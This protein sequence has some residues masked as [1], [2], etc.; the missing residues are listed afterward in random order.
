MTEVRLDS[1]RR[2]DAAVVGYPIMA[3][4]FVL[5]AALLFDVAP[6]AVGLLAVLTGLAVWT[7][8]KVLAPGRY[9]HFYA[10]ILAAKLALLVYQI[11]FKN[12][13]LS[14]V[15]WRFYHQ[16]GA[17][18]A[19]DTNGHLSQ[20]IASQYDLFTRLTAVVY[21]VFG[22]DPEQMYFVVFITSLVTFRYVYGAAEI[23]LKNRVAAQSVALLFMVWPN[24]I[25]MS[26]T[27]LREMPI[28]MLL[29]A[30]LYYFLHFWSGRGP[31]HLALAIGLSLAAT[32]MHSGVIAVPIVYAYLAVRAREGGGI[33]IVR[34]AGFAVLAFAVLRS[35]VASPF[36]AKFGDLSDPSMILDLGGAGY[37]EAVGATTYYLNPGLGDAPLIQLPY[38]FI[39]FALSPLP[40]QATN[41]STAVSVVIE[42]LPRLLMVTML[43]LCYRRCRTGEP[44]R[45][46]LL[47]GVLFAIVATYVIFS[48]GVSTYGS[49]IR[50]RAKLF[51]IEIILAYATFTAGR[52][53]PISP[54]NSAG[55]AQ[56][57]IGR[58]RTQ[59]SDDTFTRQ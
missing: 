37:A 54:P 58:R 21:S 49:A 47:L 33:Q 13:P 46:I 59:T 38:R 4:L 48:P 28:Q 3:A 53:K 55:R 56:R 26:I 10:L 11:Q 51:P 42:G 36:L 2:A 7:N 57:A 40:W 16:S 50:H 27:F 29:A 15:D 44:R 24:E 23:L 20:I 25:V 14:G 5:A 41:L 6:A 18:L 17:L 22:M 35:P 34:T 12:L 52:Y 30:S 43:L 39:M 45:D 8:T 9:V 19:T 31:Q 32:L 1:P